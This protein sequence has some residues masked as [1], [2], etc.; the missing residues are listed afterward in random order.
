M[1]DQQDLGA[2]EFRNADNHVA[3]VVGFALTQTSARLVHHHEPRLSDDAAR[4]LDQPPFAGVE[5]R[6]D[7]LRLAV[8]PDIVQ[9][10]G[11]EIVPDAA[12]GRQIVERR[13]DVVPDR[14]IFDH[15]LGLK[16]AA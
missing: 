9:C 6:T 10:F 14:Q 13:G 4:D 2:A 12:A 16:G 5:H 11:D 8:Q 1:I 7:T 15:L 3:Q